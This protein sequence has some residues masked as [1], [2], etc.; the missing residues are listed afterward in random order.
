MTTALETT[1]Q[2]PDQAAL[3]VALRVSGKKIDRFQRG[4]RVAQGREAASGIAE[5]CVLDL[6]RVAE[7][8]ADEA[9][10]GTRF[11]EPLARVVDALFGRPFR[12][13]KLI[14]REIDA[15]DHDPRHRRRDRFT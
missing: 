3:V 4:V 12:V 9:D 13:E 10:R 7:G 6:E 8:E 15:L 5:P 1:A 2:P 14:E 11:L